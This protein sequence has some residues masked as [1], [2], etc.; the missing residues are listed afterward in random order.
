MYDEFVSKLYDL[1][2]VSKKTGKKKT[3][4]DAAHAIEYLSNL[5]FVWKH[6][7]EDLLEAQR[8][9]PVTEKLP[10]LH[11]EDASDCFED[12]SDCGEAGWFTSGQVLILRNGVIAIG[13]YVEYSDDDAGWESD[14]GSC[15]EVTHW[16]PLPALPEGSGA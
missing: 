14:G 10:E 6:K 4:F 8:W 1:A 3:Y 7:Y 2:A 9:V 13:E 12:A 11:F 5:S 15:G 16:K